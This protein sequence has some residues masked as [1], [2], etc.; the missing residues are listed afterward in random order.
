MLTILF[1]V[2]VIVQYTCISIKNKVHYVLGN[3]I[4]YHV[5]IPP[6]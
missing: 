5:G 6:R 1:D 3:Y 4:V 2:S